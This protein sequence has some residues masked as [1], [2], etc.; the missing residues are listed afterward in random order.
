MNGNWLMEK[1]EEPQEGPGDQRAVCDDPW[2][3]RASPHESL[4]KG[5]GGGR[6]WTWEEGTAVVGLLGEGWILFR[7]QQGS[8]ART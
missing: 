8:P 5:C 2:G 6:V 1:M 4:A 3:R 7:T